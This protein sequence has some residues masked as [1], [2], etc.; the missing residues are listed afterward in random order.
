MIRNLAVLVFVLLAGC[1]QQSF[2][3]RYK[4]AQHRLDA[5]TAGIDKELASMESDAAEADALPTDAAL[6]DVPPSDGKPAKAR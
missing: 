5:K 2:D 4:S 6:P 3:E 1:K